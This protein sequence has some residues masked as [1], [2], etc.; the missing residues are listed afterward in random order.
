MET[1]IK[2]EKK[3]IRHKR[4]KIKV[5]G[6]AARPRFY[7]FRSN[8]HIYAQLIDDVKGRTIIVAGDLEARKTEKQTG[9]D[10]RSLTGKIAMAYEVGK[11]IA[12]KALVKKIEKVVFDRG[13]CKY[14]GRIK[15][16]ADG[17]REGGLKF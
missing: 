1:K 12:G 17:A 6:T 10:D 16:V 11:L 8:K 5:F 14:H 4:I 15:A 9:K 3:I 13:G 7:V 2:R